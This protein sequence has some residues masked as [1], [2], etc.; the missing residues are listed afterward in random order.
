LFRVDPERRFFTPLSKAE[1]G[2]A[3]G[4]NK[5]YFKIKDLTFKISMVYDEHHFNDA[6]YD[7]IQKK[8]QKKKEVI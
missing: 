6:Q 1:L 2:T 7:A 4:V 8:F 5:S 3:E